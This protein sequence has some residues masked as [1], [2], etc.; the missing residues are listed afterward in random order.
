MEKLI[1]LIESILFRLTPDLAILPL[2]RGSQ[3]LW[4]KLPVAMRTAQELF[5]VAD[6]QALQTSDPA[7]LSS[8]IV[9]LRS[10]NEF[11]GRFKWEFS[12]QPDSV[13]VAGMNWRPME[14]LVEQI[15][16]ETLLYREVIVNL[17]PP[18]VV[19]QVRQH[20]ALAP[21]AYRECTIAFLDV[22]SFS[23]I[24]FQL[25]PVSLI[26]KL[27]EYFSRFDRIVSSFALAKI[28]TIGDAYMLVSGIPQRRPSH[29]VDACLAGLH[30][31]ASVKEPRRVSRQMRVITSKSSEI[32]IDEWQF[33]LGIHSGP[34]I[35]GVLGSAKYLFDVWG[36]SV[37]IAARM[38]GVG[39]PGRPTVSGSTYELIKDYFVCTPFGKR[40]VKNVGE[41]DVYRVDRLQ[42]EYAADAAGLQPSKAYLQRYLQDFGRGQPRPPIEWTPPIYHPLLASL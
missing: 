18:F 14:E 20:K 41:V 6:Y 29:A 15:S 8:R 25:D 3:T 13:L 37:N 10:Q 7:T 42:P 11:L 16:K 30:L 21:K 23:K 9:E 2:S 39:E 4:E 35:T 38:E 19:E 1:S 28:K 32:D 36:D 40:A 33:R 22:V 31:L 24:A 27:D 12:I 26:R 17:L 5:G 34:C